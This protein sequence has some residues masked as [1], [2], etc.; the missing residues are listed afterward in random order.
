MPRGS[1]PVAL[2][3]AGSD[4]GGGA[5]LQADLKTFAA[6]GV[7]GTSAVTCLTAQNPDGVMGVFAVPE[8]FV[9]L[10]IR[11]VC[12]AFPV[13]AAKTGML[14]SASMIRSVAKAL[15]G[16]PIRK[17]VVDPVMVATSGARLLQPDALR[18]LR[19]HLLPVAS[20]VT[21][22]L[23]EAEALLGEPIADLRGLR[24]AA[25]ALERRFGTAFVLKGGHLPGVRVTDVLCVRGRILEWTSPRVAA[26]ETHGTGCTFSAALAARLA[27]GASLEN[28]TAA[29]KRFVNSALAKARRAGQHWPLAVGD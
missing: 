15:T 28:A 11:A 6:C 13:A 7:F 17:L 21:P 19:D 14:F 27:C 8:T 16:A 3:V 12:R 9:S 29:A 18:A 5:G 25:R 26:R 22:N 10:Q 24:E 4:S 20:V 1:I 23:P 2:T